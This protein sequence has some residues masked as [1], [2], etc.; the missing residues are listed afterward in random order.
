MNEVRRICVSAE[1]LLSGAA[2]TAT[3]D[4]LVGTVALAAYGVP[5]LF[6]LKK[7]TNSLLYTDGVSLVALFQFW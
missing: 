7:P 6:C 5:P 3:R 4:M 2:V 1:R